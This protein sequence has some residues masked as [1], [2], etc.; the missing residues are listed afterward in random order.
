MT[1]DFRITIDDAEV[2]RMLDRAPGQIGQACR[3]GLLDGALYLKRILTTYP[4]QRSG[5]TY[6]RTLTLGRS[7]F[8]QLHGAGVDTTAEVFSAGNIAPYNRLV[9]DRT[10]QARVHRGRWPTAQGVAEQSRQQVTQ[11]LVRRLQEALGR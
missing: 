5:S 2:R 11:F 1:I 8:Y 4:P 9:Q 7:W 6:R 3:A 10:R